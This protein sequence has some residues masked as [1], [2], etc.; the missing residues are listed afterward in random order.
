LLTNLYLQNYL[1][2]EELSLDFTAGLNIFTGETGSGKSI[3]LEA[4]QGLISARLTP[5]LIRPGAN[6][7]YLEGT[8][9]VDQEIQTWL[10]SQELEAE[11]QLII[12]REITFKGSRARLNGVL[13]TA[14]LAAELG[15]KLLEIHGQ[16]SEQGL[17]SSQNQ[18]E[19][20][21]KHAGSAHV[22]LVQQFKHDYSA[23]K[24]LNK[25]I[26]DAQQHQEAQIKQSDYLNFQQQEIE[27]LNLQNSA[28]EEELKHKINNLASLENIQAAMQEIEQVFSAAEPNLAEMLGQSLRKLQNASKD[29][30]QLKTLSTDL[31][32]TYQQLSELIRELNFYDLS[33]AE[34]LDL[35]A[36]NKR[37]NDIQK[38]RRKHNCA[39]LA[40]LMAL[41]QELQKQLSDLENFEQNLGALQL[42]QK[43]QVHKLNELAKKLSENRAGAAFQISTYVNQNLANLGL[44]GAKFT[45]D[46]QQ[47]TSF[48]QAGW[49]Q[50]NFLFQA[51]VGDTLKPLGKVASGG[52]ISR[53]NL[54]LKSLIGGQNQTLLFDEI[55]AGTSGKVCSLIAEKL[56]KLSRQQQILC[57]THQP[58]VAAFGDLNFMVYKQH[59]KNDTKL[60]VQL[61]KEPEQKIEALVDLM[62]GEKDTIVAKKYISDLITQANHKKN[63]HK[64]SASLA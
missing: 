40:D 59:G 6:K 10:N 25:Q 31:Q 20:L 57:V 52:E 62:S 2:I 49:D 44:Q 26:E 53:L 22:A 42:K 24:A 1:L 14:K 56:H 46:C 4:I 38:L 32:N 43:K 15:H 8:F 48:S 54:L 19:L 64:L 45:V 61:L 3:I 35:E 28:E 11:S 7:A 47:I 34:T 51:N 60:N 41:Q 13:I 18:L 21:D 39:N 27:A 55:D 50:I 36:L 12:S 63:E 33:E 37:L 29:H 23:Y 9:E 5:D 17:L 30:P 58:S 16:N